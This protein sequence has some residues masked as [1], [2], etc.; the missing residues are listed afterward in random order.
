MI[1]ILWLTKFHV[2]VTITYLVCV[3]IFE[4]KTVMVSR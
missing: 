4:G 2:S 1:H 3:C